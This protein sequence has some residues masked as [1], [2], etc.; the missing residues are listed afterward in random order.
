MIE[1]VVD[2]AAIASASTKR[3]SLW[4]LA[5]RN[6]SVIVGGIILFSYNSL[7]APTRGSGYLSQLG[8]AAFSMQF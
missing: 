5:I 3:R 1:D 8:K 6:S 7:V 2:S 4:A